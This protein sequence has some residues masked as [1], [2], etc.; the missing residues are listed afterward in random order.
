MSVSSNVFGDHADP[1]VDD[2]QKSA[3]NLEP[4]IGPT[5]PHDESSLAEQRHE[6]SVV[7]QDADLAVVRGRDYRVRLAVK[8]GCFRR[9]HR[10]LHLALASLRAFSTASSIPPTM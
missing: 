4:V 10:D 9:N 3:S 6:R 1:I 8:H 7:R 2:L 5:L